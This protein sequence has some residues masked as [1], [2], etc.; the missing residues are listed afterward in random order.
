MMKKQEHGLFSLFMKNL[1]H[2]SEALFP[3]M[4]ETEIKEIVKV[5]KCGNLMFALGLVFCCLS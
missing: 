5:R 2:F 4:A 1:L 3:H